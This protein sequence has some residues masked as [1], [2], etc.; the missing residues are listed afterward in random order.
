MTLTPTLTS[1]VGEGVGGWV[2]VVGQGWGGVKV[3]GQGWRRGQGCWS[4]S[5]SRLGLGEGQG[6]GVKG[7][8]MVGGLGVGV[9]GAVG[10]RHWV[11][12]GM[13]WF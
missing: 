12:H 7:G 6:Q 1:L 10:F 2:K 3:R 11:K 9:R 13:E 5:G 4:R 8:V